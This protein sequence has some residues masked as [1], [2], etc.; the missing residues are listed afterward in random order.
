[1]KRSALRATDAV[2]TAVLILMMVMFISHPA[3]ATAPGAVQVPGVERDTAK[4]ELPLQGR[5]AISAALGKE[6][7]SY[8]LISQNE[9]LRA[10]NPAQSFTAR[11]SPEG[12]IV[13]TPTASLAMSLSAVGYGKRLVPVQPARPRA[14]TNRAEYRRGPLTEWY[15]NGPFGL[16]QGFTLDAPPA[17]TADQKAPLILAL[18]LKGTL[19][20]QLKPDRRSLVFTDGNTT[21]RFTYT[22][23]TVTDAEGN[24]APS[25]LE[26]HGTTLSITVDDRG[27]RYPLTIDPFFQAA[28]LTASDGAASDL[29]GYSVAISGNTVVVGACSKARLGA[30]Y[31]FEKP[32]TGWETMTQ[33]AKLTA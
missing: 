27:M 9:D 14:R 5:Y 18:S 15:V 8:H 31:V 7:E 30:A 24:E 10:P 20:A 33:T 21:A 13:E 1:M 25:W 26:V 19:T 22:G 2:L 32:G 29:F 11:F 4:Q 28:K 3:L 12:L 23:L 17:A 16:Q 6:Q